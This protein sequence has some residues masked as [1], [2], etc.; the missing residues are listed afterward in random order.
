MEDN[1]QE[2]GWPWKQ[3][4]NESMLITLK[5]WNW[6]LSASQACCSHHSSMLPTVVSTSNFEVSGLPGTTGPCRA[7]SAVVYYRVTNV[8]GAA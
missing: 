3:W 7:D 8:P 5:R 6:G 4:Y 1:V 2:S